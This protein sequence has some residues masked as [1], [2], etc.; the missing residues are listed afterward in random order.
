MI[1]SLL[2]SALL[3]KIWNKNVCFASCEVGAL[4]QNNCIFCHFQIEE[5]VEK[6]K[7]LKLELTEDGAANPGSGKVILKTAKGTR[8]YQPEQV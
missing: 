4:K 7:A 6:L 3:S 5:E 2:N 8:D 1:V